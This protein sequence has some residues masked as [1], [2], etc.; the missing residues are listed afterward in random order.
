MTLSERR[1]LQTF[2]TRAL[3]ARNERNTDKAGEVSSTLVGV[4]VGVIG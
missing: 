2:G 4:D 1:R 3:R